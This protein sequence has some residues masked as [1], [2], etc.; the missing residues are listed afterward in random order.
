[1]VLIELVTNG[2]HFKSLGLGG[3]R[4]GLLRLDEVDDESS[5]VLYKNLF[6]FVV[7]ERWGVVNERRQGATSLFTFDVDLSL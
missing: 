2:G 3:V 6:L 1:M 5:W 4:R 7:P